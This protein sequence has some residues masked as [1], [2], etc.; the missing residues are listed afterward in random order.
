MSPGADSAGQP[1]E[2]RSF[3]ANPFAGDSGEVDQ[4]LGD[5]LAAFQELLKADPEQRTQVELATAWGHCVTALGRARVLSPLIAEAGDWGVSETGALVEKTQELSVPQLEGPDGRAV[6]PVFRDVAAMARWNSAARPIPVEGSRAALAAAS[7]GLALVLDPGSPGARVFRRSALQAAAS[8]TD[9]LAPWSD[10]AVRAGFAAVLS[11]YS[12]VAVH[13][14]ICGD[15]SQTLAGPEVL[16]VL[17]VVRGL[18]PDVV[19]SMLA[20]I[21]ARWASDPVI[22]ERCDG[23]GV[24]VLPA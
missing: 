8:G 9:Y 21:S 18:G 19:A 23:V 15:P 3:S 7:E 22:A 24:K 11:D 20:E 6:A 12:E 16:V 1:F 5:T 2:G 14:V 10:D 17:G 4:V 13:R